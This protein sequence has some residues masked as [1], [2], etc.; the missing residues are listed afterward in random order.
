MLNKDLNI[1]GTAILKMKLEEY[2]KAISECPDEIVELNRRKLHRLT[3]DFGVYDNWPILTNADYNKVVEDFKKNPKWEYKGEGISH[4]NPQLISDAFDYIPGVIVM[5]MQ[6]FV[7]RIDS[8]G[9]SPKQE[10][11]FNMG[12]C[13][14]P[15]QPHTGN[16]QKIR[17]QAITDIANYLV[18]SNLP[19][20]FP[21]SRGWKNR[22]DKSQIVYWPDEL[23]DEIQK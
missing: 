1:I 21:R 2:L 16:W 15:Y 20:C 6:N 17:V 3:V 14:H 5:G 10:E 4:S 22:E 9:L 19:V 8:F 11:F 23:H 13:L 12:F 18:G 7:P